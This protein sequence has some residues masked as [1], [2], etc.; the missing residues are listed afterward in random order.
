MS[1]SSLEL[2]TR[3]G[4]ALAIGL[5]LGLERG[6][7][8]RELPE[9]ERVAGFRTFGLLSLLGAVASLVS[10]GEPAVVAAALLAVGAIVAVGYLRTSRE[11]TERSATG[12][13]AALLAFALG[14]MAGRGDVETAAAIAVVA[15]MLL[16]AKPELHRWLRTIEREELLATFRLLLISV[17]ALPV[18]PDRGFGPWGVL[19]P[20]RIWWMVVLVAA[21]SYVGYLAKRLWGRDRG[22]LIGGVIGGLVS[23]T[24]VTIALS[25]RASADR[26]GYERLTAATVVASAIMF[27]RILAILAPMSIELCR[28]VF[29]P[30]AA[31]AAVAGS[32]AALFVLRAR[33]TDG[34]DVADALAVEN[35]L[36]LASALKF[37]LLLSAILVVSRALIAALGDRGL[38][39]GAAAAGL[40]DVD[41]I[42]LSIAAMMNRGEIAGATAVGAVLLAAATNTAVKSALAITIGGRRFGARVAISLVAALVGGTALWA[43]RLA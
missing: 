39:L 23:S 20:Y 22:T 26:G 10:N 2:T 28:L 5:L 6:W 11:R 30:V 34:R 16:G 42:T 31:A 35:P 14:A 19:N 1:G 41:A 9:G 7:Q 8:L 4:G 13:V 27:L 29:V 37:G 21:V 33:R 3:V 32:A 36:D 17:V 43:I 25:R 18:L 12:M 38:Y 40:A 24:A 15:T